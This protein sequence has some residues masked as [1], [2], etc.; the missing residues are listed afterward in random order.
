M[1]STTP[2]RGRYEATAAPDARPPSGP[3][4]SLPLSVGQEAMWVS[5]KVDPRQRTHIVPSPFLV[6]G[7]L[8]TA[9]LTAAVDQLGRRHPTLRAR[10]V[11]DTDGTWLTWAGAPGIP[12]AEHKSDKTLDESVRSLW[13][14]PFDLDSGPL[15]RVDVV[16]GQDWTVLLITVHHIVFDGASVLLLLAELR[17]AYAGT[18][19]GGPDDPEPLAAFARRS[20]AYADGPEGEE[21]RSF[22]RRHLGDD[23]PGLRLPASLD[24]PGYTVHRSDLDPELSAGVNRCAARLGVSRFT[25][26]YGA[27]LVLLRHFSGQD[28]LLVSAPYHG[29]DTPDLKDRIGFFVNALPIRQRLNGDDTYASFLRRLRADLRLCQAHGNLPLPA[30]QRQAGLT[31]RAGRR[32]S[33]QAVFAFW[34]ASRAADVNVKAFPLDAGGTTCTLRLLDMEGAADYTLTTMVREDGGATSVLWKDPQGAVGPRLIAE[35]AEQYLHTLADIVADPERRLAQPATDTATAPVVPDEH[36]RVPAAD[37]NTATASGPPSLAEPGT[38][39]A[40]AGAHTDALARVWAQV[41]DCVPPGDD[42]DFFELG[43]HS[44]LANTL[45]EQVDEHFGARISLHELFEFSR[46][47]DF[48]T[49]LEGRLPQPDT[50]EESDPSVFPASGFQERIWFAER[51]EP[52][53]T[54]YNVPLCWTVDGRLDAVVLERAL[55]LLVERH[56]ILRTR[57]VEHDGRLL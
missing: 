43:G 25:V 48:V 6:E 3:D 47:G 9:R 38:G 2:N 11:R 54:L 42:D 16:H 56:E 36:P 33:H 17:K 32:R 31:G 39:G 10:I 30:I 29:R 51:L 24:P 37:G 23:V 55:A 41:L 49:L 12:V 40:G 15:A 34:D 57:F 22:W 26:L 18:P 4:N 14:R 52:G 20:R 46:F 28:D 21:L 45:L 53:T 7:E 13:Q 35:M 19:L 50:A 44:L 8:D 27:Y 5:W 1:T